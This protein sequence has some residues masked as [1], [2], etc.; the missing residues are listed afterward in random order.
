MTTKKARYPE[1]RV[2]W[3]DSRQADATW[4]PLD[5]VLDNLPKPCMC[6]T[7]AWLIY[8]DNN[9][10]V[11]AS[12]LVFEENNDQIA[13]VMVIPK[14]A[15]IHVQTLVDAEAVKFKRQ[16]P[17]LT[18][19][20]KAAEQMTQDLDQCGM[21]QPV[22]RVGSSFVPHTILTKPY[23]WVMLTPDRD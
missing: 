15:V 2:R 7:T 18:G 4:Q 22:W 13:G 17:P 12:C 19:Y 20:K 5:E 16:D 23:Q 1:V 10:V 11:L 3:V 8:S 14:Q 6:E 21:T 9:K